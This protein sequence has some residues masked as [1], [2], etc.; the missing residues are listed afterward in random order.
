MK[1]HIKKY[2]PQKIIIGAISLR[3][4]F[5]KNYFELFL[6]YKIHNFI[7]FLPYIFQIR[8]YPNQANEHLLIDHTFYLPLSRVKYGG[9][10]KNINKAKFIMKGDW[11]I[12]DKIDIEKYILN[13]TFMKAVHDIF[14]SKKRYQQTDQ[15]IE[16][17]EI[18]NSNNPKNWKARGCKNIS[19]VHNYFEK[20]NKIFLDI[21]KNGFQT[22]IELGSDRKNNEIQLYI[23]RNG[24]VCKFQGQGHHRLAIAFVLNLDKIPCRIISVHHNFY[25]NHH[26]YGSNILKTTKLLINKMEKEI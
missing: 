14:A 20:L 5:R 12:S 15:F 18:V 16:M 9:R 23:D 1:K 26:K 3:N 24:D 22:Q 10:P 13:D 21:K 6:K 19:D 17:I 25:I 7:R 11:D 2:T 4:S 8:L